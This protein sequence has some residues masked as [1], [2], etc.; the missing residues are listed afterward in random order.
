MNVIA[1]GIQVVDAT[2][3][4]PRSERVR[5]Q[6]FAAAAELGAAGE[7]FSVSKLVRQAGVSRSVFYLHFNDLSDF[8]LHLQ[9]IHI[10]EIARAAALDRQADPHASMLQSQ[11]ALISHIAMNRSLYRAAFALA[12]SRATGEG[13]AA[14]IAGALR[15]HI[16]AVGTMPAG[17]RV[18]MVAAYIAEAVTG[19][20]TAWLLDEFVASEEELAQHLFQLLPSWMHDESQTTADTHGGSNNK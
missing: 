1:D 2:K 16:E 19:L 12:E 4:D 10:D 20:I 13:T 9:R 3:M 17:L 5:A 7:S 11:R 8:A 6:L 18:E 14:T 15:S